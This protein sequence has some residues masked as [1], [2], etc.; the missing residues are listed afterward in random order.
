MYA[1]KLNPILGDIE[2]KEIDVAGGSV[3]GIVLSIINS[4]IN[5][6]CNLTKDKKSYIEVQNEVIEISN[7]ANELKEKALNAIDK[8]EKIVGEML[9]AYK[10]RKEKPDDYEQ[11]IKESTEFCI[12]V[13][14]IALETL[15]LAVQM[16][17]IGNRMLVSDFNICRIYSFASVKASIENV[18]I[19]VQ[20]IQDEEYKNIL[21]DKYKKIYEEAEN[22]NMEVI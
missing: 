3:V 19:N 1:K 22:I 5:Y 20:A 14:E 15:K 8:D 13:T 4:L 12:E 6:T 9:T 17:K 7:K 10:N 16:S 18:K 2:N 11:I 21:I